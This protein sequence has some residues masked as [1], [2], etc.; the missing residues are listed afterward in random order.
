MKRY[1]QELE[2]LV[3]ALL[4][5]TVFAFAAG[6]SIENRVLVYARPGRW[7][8][9]FV[10]LGV[11]LVYATVSWTRN[12]L[13][14]RFLTLAAGL[15]AVALASTTWSVDASLT[16]RRAGSLGV[17]F[18]LATALLVG[19]PRRVLI[20]LLTG[21]AVVGIAGLGTLAFDH[22]AAVQPASTQYPARFQGFEQNPDTAALLFALAIPI[23][24]YLLLAARTPLAKLILTAALLLFAGSITASGARGPMLAAFAGTLVVLLSATRGRRRIVLVAVAVAAF[25]ASVGISRIPQAKPAPPSTS[26]VPVIRRTLLT[27]SGRRAAWAGG[28]HQAEAR[29]IAGY[30]FGTEALVFV[31]RYA[32]FDSDL[33]ENT[34][35]GVALQ[36][37]LVGLGLL[38]AVA[39]AAL[40]PFARAPSGGIE[41]AFA[42]VTV[43]ALVLAIAQSYLLSVGN[44][45]TLTAW[46]S[47][48]LL[49]ALSRQAGPVPRGSPP[50]TLRAPSPG[51]R[52]GSAPGP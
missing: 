45:G 7:V 51:S 47:L 49:A 28:I 12:R 3:A 40:L 31:D 32:N 8:C 41:A 2:W 39:V 22:D 17:L 35:I 23:A 48:F 30:G 46:V 13:P 11:A 15:I 6:S 19:S 42:G 38:L 36:V 26:G 33:V 10:L 18:A 50:E 29:P 5:V 14:W 52:V 25:G 44:I 1:K 4:A 20:G 37:G 34:Y 21:A 27:S 16:L 9:L 43:A 24:A